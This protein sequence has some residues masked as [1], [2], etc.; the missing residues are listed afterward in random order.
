MNTIK[1]AVFVV[2]AALLLWVG[3]VYNRKL[4]EKAAQQ[5]REVAQEAK[6]SQD[7]I[8]N[9]LIKEDVIVGTGEEVKSGDIVSVH[10]TGTFTD[11]KKFDSSYDRGTPF[12]FT[13]GQGSVIQGWDLGVVGMKV[14]G[15]RKLTI[16]PELGYGNKDYSVIPGNSTLKFTIDLLGIKHPEAKQ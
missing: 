9:S 4:D 11:G 12:E 6:Q 2:V 10:Y 5:D 7:K 13:V 16:P 3:T 14:G 15:E 8:M 1:V